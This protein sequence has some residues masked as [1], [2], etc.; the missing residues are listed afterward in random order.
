LGIK[1]RYS[2]R[3][4]ELKRERGKEEGMHPKDD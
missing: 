1:E 2:K 3:K 4:Q